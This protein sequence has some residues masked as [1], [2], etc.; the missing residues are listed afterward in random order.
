[1][2]LGRPL[3]VIITKID[4]LSLGLSLF[5]GQSPT[6]SPYYGVMLPFQRLVLVPMKVAWITSIIPKGKGSVFP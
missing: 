1:M 3:E 4:W 2:W 5:S 6:S